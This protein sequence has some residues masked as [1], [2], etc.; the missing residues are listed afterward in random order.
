M[1]IFKLLLIFPGKGRMARRN[2]FLSDT[3]FVN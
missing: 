2:A 3:I 1:V